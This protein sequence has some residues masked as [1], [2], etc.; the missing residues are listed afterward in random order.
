MP[1][2]LSGLWED[3]ANLG[4]I[5]VATWVAGA[6]VNWF[7]SGEPT[8]I[9]GNGIMSWVHTNDAVFSGI[10]GTA[11][12]VVQAGDISGGTVTLRLRWHSSGNLNLRAAT[13]DPLVFAA[14]VFRL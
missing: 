9:S 11:H 10:G 2:D 1:G 7:G 13:T 4:F 14:K 12:L 6:G 5:D 3:Q 8:T